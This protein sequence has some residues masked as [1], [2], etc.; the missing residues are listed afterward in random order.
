MWINRAV[1][2]FEINRRLHLLRSELA[3]LSQ[4]FVVV[5]FCDI[6]GD[7]VTELDEIHIAVAI[8]IFAAGVLWNRGEIIVDNAAHDQWAAILKSLEALIDGVLINASA[9][10]FKSIRFDAAWIGNA[11]HA[12]RISCAD[13]I[14]I[15]DKDHGQSRVLAIKSLSTNR[16]ELSVFHG[17]ID[18]VKAFFTA[19]GINVIRSL[20][21]VLIKSSTELRH[22]HALGAQDVR[23]VLIFI[24]RTC[25]SSATAMR[26]HDRDPKIRLWRKLGYER[27]NT[28]RETGFLIGHG[29]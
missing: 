5:S 8:L 6:H 18:R 10:S 7:T 13:V 29:A 16:I 17:A 20:D 15:C 26:R 12:R 22:A 25:V 19:T 3:D 28:F 9:I 1:C 27:L 24:K 21:H 14:L 4:A 11:L 2:Q 23:I